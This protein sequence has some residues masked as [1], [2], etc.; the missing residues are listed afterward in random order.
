LGKSPPGGQDE[1]DDWGRVHRAART[2]MTIG[3][4]PTGGPGQI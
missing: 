4:G 2:N 1:Y 3:E